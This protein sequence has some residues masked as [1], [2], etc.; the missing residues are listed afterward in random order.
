M[1]IAAATRTVI[2]PSVS[3]PRMSTRI[4]LTTLRPWPSGH[5][6]SD[7]ARTPARPCAPGRHGRHHD[8]RPDH[9]RDAEAHQAAGA[10]PAV[11]EAVG[12]PAQHEQ[13]D[14]DEQRLDAEL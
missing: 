1:P 12:Q 14:D 13:E 4:T 5:A 10:G 2:S 11:L 9:R 8:E 7:I 3:K 6:C